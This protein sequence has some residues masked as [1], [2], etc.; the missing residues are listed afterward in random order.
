MRGKIL[1]FS[2]FLSSLPEYTVH[3]NYISVRNIE[4]TNIRTDGVILNYS[5]FF[6]NCFLC[7]VLIK[8]FDYHQ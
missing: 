5:H 4:K 1:R 8:I 7:H 2:S 6:Q 3:V